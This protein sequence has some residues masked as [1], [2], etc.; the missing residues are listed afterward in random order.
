M[1]DIGKKKR[2]ERRRQRMSKRTLDLEAP[3]QG[4]RG[5]SRITGLSIGYL[6]EGCKNGTVPYIMVS[7][8]YRVN[9][10]LLLRMLNGESVAN[11]KGEVVE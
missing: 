5:A 3:F 7:T 4:L 1:N 2:G 10:P 11:L 6:R 9:V 8:E